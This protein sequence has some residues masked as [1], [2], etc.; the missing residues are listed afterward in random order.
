MQ[1]R[2]TSILLMCWLPL[3]LGLVP[4][5]AP[6]LGPNLLRSAVVPT[7]APLMRPSRIR[8]ATH[9]IRLCAADEENNAEKEEMDWREMRARLVA[10]EQGATGGEDFVYESPLIEQGSVILGGTKQDF[11]FALRQQYFHKCGASSAAGLHRATAGFASL[12]V[13]L[14]PGPACLLAC[15][16]PSLRA[17]LPRVLRWRPSPHAVFTLRRPPVGRHCL[18]VVML[19]LQHDESFRIQSRSLKL[20]IFKVLTQFR[21]P[22]CFS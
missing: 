19:L 9:V 15:L 1:Q 14:P 16:P 21:R 17:S 22:L 7:V 3:V 4:S 6:L 13:C 5:A 18:S 2:L 20:V 11:G 12:F 10:G 8:L